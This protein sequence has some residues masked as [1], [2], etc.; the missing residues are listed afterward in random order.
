MCGSLQ[1]R[2]ASQ[3]PCRG[4]PGRSDAGAAYPS[5]V[6][7]C[8]RLS[9]PTRSRGLR[10]PRRHLQSGVMLDDLGPRICIMGPPNSGRST[11]AAAVCQAKALEIVHLDQ[12]YHLPHTDRVPRPAD[13]F[14]ALNDAAVSGSRW[15]IVL[16]PSSRE[17]SQLLS[18]PTAGMR[19]QKVDCLQPS[20]RRCSAI[21]ELIKR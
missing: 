13:E 9:F 10:Q 5:K 4:K 18:M 11:L 14:V 12:R 15:V 19:F 6:Y 8:S 17:G 2:W 16:I 3:P 20:I 7:G 1:R 21:G